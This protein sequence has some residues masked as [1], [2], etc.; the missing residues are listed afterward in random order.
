MKS[1]LIS[2]TVFLSITL[3]AQST[4]S[5]PL[6]ARHD[7]LPLTTPTPAPLPPS[8]PHV[9][10]TITSHAPTTSDEDCDDVTSNVP[11]VGVKPKVPGDKGKPNLPKPD[12][13]PGDKGKPNLPKPDEKPGDK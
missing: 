13:K 7:V 3:F 10:G 4:V 9:P 2:V 11:E 1:N 6:Q 5:L 12:E 8:L